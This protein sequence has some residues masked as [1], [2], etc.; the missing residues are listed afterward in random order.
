MNALL[1][2]ILF[3]RF[4]HKHHVQI[5]IL[6]EEANAFSFLKCLIIIYSCE[7]SRG[8]D[9]STRRNVAYSLR[10]RSAFCVFS[11]AM[12]ASISM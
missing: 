3:K 1:G 9:L 7:Q 8:Y 6:I 4:T 11:S 12:L 5:L 2:S 10:W